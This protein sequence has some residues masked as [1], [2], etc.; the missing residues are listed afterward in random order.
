MA[1]KDGQE[2]FLMERLAA[3]VKVILL[4]DADACKAW[5]TTLPIKN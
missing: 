5:H 1:Y 4:V 3:I 2:M